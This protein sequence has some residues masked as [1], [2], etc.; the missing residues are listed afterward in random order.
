[1]RE[2]LTRA[3][4]AGRAGVWHGRGYWRGLHRR[5]RWWLGGSRR[6]ARRFGPQGCRT[7]LAA[8]GRWVGRR[9]RRLSAL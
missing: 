6:G 5:N 1:L 3:G 2:R 4:L 9:H 7:S 8:L